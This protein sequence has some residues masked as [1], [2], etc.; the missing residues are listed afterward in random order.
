MRDALSL[1]DQCIAFHYGKELTYDMVLDVLGAVDT[2]VFSDLLRKILKQDV[3]GCIALLEKMIMQGR[4][5]VQFVTDF[6]WY[7]RNLLLVKASNNPEEIL[8]MSGENLKRLKQ[9][10]EIIELTSV[11]RYIRILSETASSLKY[12]SA[13]RV[14][15]EITL[16]KLCKPQMEVEVDSIAERVR[17]IED[18]LERGVIKERQPRSEDGNVSEPKKEVRKE[19]PKAIPEEIKMVIRKWQGIIQRVNMPLKGYLNECRL[20]MGENQRLLLVTED[21]VVSDYLLK[22]EGVKEQIISLIEEYID[23][24]VELEIRVLQGD[25]SFEENYIDLTK[26]INIEIEEEE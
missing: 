23:R 16:I 3:A 20:S 26:I 18:Q 1:L 5:L 9:E 12:S 7:L 24:K 15:L 21:G 10:A 6:T 8:D 13:K 14:L 2:E 4:E 25:R 19:L 22:H 11:F 17:V